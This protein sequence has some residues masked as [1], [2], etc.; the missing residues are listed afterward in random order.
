MLFHKH[1]WIHIEKKVK[2]FKEYENGYKIYEREV[3]ECPKCGKQQM[4]K[5]PYS[6]RFVWKL[7][8]QLLDDW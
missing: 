7:R 4:W 1:T 8:S 5:H 3:V 2:W 6:P